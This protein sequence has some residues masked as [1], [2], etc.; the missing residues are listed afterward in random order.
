MRLTVPAWCHLLRQSERAARLRE[1]AQRLVNKARNI[2]QRIIFDEA[3]AVLDKQ[4][5]VKGAGKIRDLRRAVGIMRFATC[6]SLSGIV[7]VEDLGAVS[8]ELEGAVFAI[9]SGASQIRI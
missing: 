5:R 7:Q 8:I 6:G 4:F 1:D 3:N 9:P 2:E